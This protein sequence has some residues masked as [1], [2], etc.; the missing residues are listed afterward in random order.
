MGVR[1]RGRTKGKG[2]WINWSWSKKN[3]LGV[4]AS[5][6]AGPFTWNSGNGKS[7]KKRITTN[8]PGGFYHVTST[9]EGKRKR[10]TSQQP[11][12]SSSEGGD[13]G[14]VL[15]FIL[16]GLPALYLIFTYPWWAFGVAVTLALLYRLGR[17]ENKP[18]EL[19][20]GYAEAVELFKDLPQEDLDALI[21]HLVEE[22]YDEQEVRDKINQVR[23]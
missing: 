17:E 23:K 11:T 3:G 2:A 5:V 16:L 9:A 8:L 13:G 15:A 14:I 22:G 19:E 10:T 7:T 20:E 6:K 4:S 1:Y 21:K 18:E 12:Y